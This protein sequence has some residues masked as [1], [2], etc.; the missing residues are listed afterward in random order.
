MPKAQTEDTL[1]SLGLTPYETKCYLAL[2][3]RGTLT[4]PE[5]STIAGVPRSNAYDALDKMMSKGICVSR[6]GNTKR[7]SASPPDLLRETLLLKV[8]EETESEL[9]KFRRDQTRA[10]EE[11]ESEMLQRKKAA[12]A[13]ITRVMREL[14]PDYEESQKQTSPLDYIEIIK[15]PY[16]IHKRF[17]ELV[18]DLREELL[19]FTKPPYTVPRERLKEQSDQQRNAVKKGIRVK[20]VY[21][22]SA[23][24]DERR[25][26]FEAAESAARR[27]AEVRVSKRLPVKMMIFDSRV[28]MFT[29]ADPVSKQPSLTTQIVE[30]QALAEALKILFNTLWEQAEDYHILKG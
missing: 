11:K 8:N 5:V 17:L 1:K 15:D 3:Q 13:D 16:Q 29:L 12:E 10:L 24:K 27:G 28:V 21:E 30:H 4:V 18:G 2:L 6:P 9:E 23:D 25:W 26:L 22:I 20:S 19:G 7:Y 14:Q